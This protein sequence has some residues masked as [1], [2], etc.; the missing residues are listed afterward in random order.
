[1]TKSVVLAKKD[2]AM[3]EQSEIHKKLWIEI[4]M[5]I[6][7]IW[8]WT[9]PA[10]QQERMPWLRPTIIRSFEL[11]SLQALV[12]YHNDKQKKNG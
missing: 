7:Q 8:L 10:Q 4:Y 11:G 9:S 6:M 2:S 12:D 5:P 1:M 3:F